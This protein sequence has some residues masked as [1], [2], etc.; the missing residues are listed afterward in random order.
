MMSRAIPPP[1]AVPSASPS[2][3]P[4]RLLSR[5]RDMAR[6]S[7]P[8]SPT[9]Q[10]AV[11]AIAAA[12]LESSAL[13]AQPVADWDEFTSAVNV[14][15]ETLETIVVGN[16]MRASTQLSASGALTID[17]G[18]TSL[19]GMKPPG[20]LFTALT[21]RKSLAMANAGTIL[22]DEATGAITSYSGGIQTRI[23]VS[24]PAQ[25]AA[26]PTLVKL[27]RMVFQKAQ[28]LSDFGGAF[29]YAEST[30][31]SG[32]T[33]YN[34]V[35]ISKSVFADNSARAYGGGVFID[36]AVSTTIEESLFQ[37]NATNVNGGALFVT[38][39][40]KTSLVDTNFI[41]NQAES[42]GGAIFVSHIYPAAIGATLRPSSP[43]EVIEGHSRY[44]PMNITIAAR[45]KDVLFEGN[46][47][48]L[49][50]DIY[51]LLGE[52]TNGGN[53]YLYP[54]AA[55]SAD[56]NL[57]ASAN[58]T[59]TFN[60]N[61]EGEG[62]Y[63]DLGESGIFETAVNININPETSSTGSVTFN[64]NLRFVDKALGASDSQLLHANINFHRGTLNIGRAS[65]LESSN[66]VLA[67]GRSA[68]RNLSFVDQKTQRHAIYSIGATEAGEHH[69]NLF[70]DVDLATG[71]SDELFLSQSDLTG[72]GTVSLDV[73]RWNVLSDM[74]DGQETATVT[75]LPENAVEHLSFG[76]T[77]EA[78]TVNGKL[79]A[80]D[81]SLV[82]P[83]NGTYTFT[84]KA[85]PP[86]A[87]ETPPSVVAPRPTDFNP[88]VYAGLLIQ[89][90]AMLLQHEIS[91]RLFESDLLL[92]GSY[93]QNRRVAGSMQG[94][95]IKADI[96]NHGSDWDLDYGI[97]LFSQMSEPSRH[98][99]F[100]AG[101]GFYG[102]V[103]VANGEDHV[104][105]VNS[106][107]AFAGFNTL[108]EAGR[109]FAFWH[110]NVGYLESDIKSSLG[111]ST[112]VNNIWVGSG[113]SLGMRFAFMNDNFRLIPSVD[114][115]Y[116][117]VNGRDLQ[118]AHGVDLD[119]DRAAGWEVSPGVRLL[120]RI[121]E[122]WNV[123]AEGRYV[124]SGD[125]GKATAVDL[126]DNIGQ[127]VGPQVLPD[128]D[129]GDYAEFAL[130]LERRAGSWIL[131][132]NLNCRA[133]EVTGW[134]LSGEALYRF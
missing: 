13:A 42:S 131:K 14:E 48:P 113:L 134:S 21:T 11:A 54:W 87:P 96:G 46:S 27:E 26:D 69:V 129:F 79:Y 41:G 35:S 3:A 5:D 132:S 76:L 40:W 1:S 55:V 44:V 77:D 73:A 70:V 24:G 34:S 49:G 121:A 119:M 68:E 78:R 102:G 88:E 125:S 124:W 110:A 123:Y 126:H 25:D 112:D 8:P 95:R 62:S 92:T 105:D 33:A 7:R 114:M 71:T 72:S 15:A 86:E 101:F 83:S 61:I 116:T 52:F 9:F 28:N 36:R 85:L 82:E 115:V 39:S 47:A 38:R 100:D 104:N 122:H 94:G 90:S 50:S 31:G 109:A 130:G 6:S 57:S 133:G 59:I 4:A 58:R 120:G 60:G 97:A 12:V 98:Q 10:I 37:N 84:S 29:S 80:Y 89:K 128:L 19:T 108:W 67:G 32:R 99:S 74:A 51:L 16:D 22:F 103:L 23:A 64:G 63:Y 20:S 18:S 75:L 56:L 91:H 30:Q 93:A 17:W 53:K 81:V 118:S 106:R 117:Y 127:P 45:G 65:T 111:G 2:A 66:L 43:L 107:G